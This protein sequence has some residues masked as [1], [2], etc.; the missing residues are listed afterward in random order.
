MKKF[1]L[2]LFIIYSSSVFSQNTGANLTQPWSNTQSLIRA[3]AVGAVRRT[4]TAFR[5]SDTSFIWIDKI[6]NNLHWRGLTNNDSTSG[7]GGGGGAYLLITDTTGKWIKNQYGTTLTGAANQ[8]LGADSIITNYITSSKDALINGLTFGKG[9]GNKLEN[10]AV[11]ITALSGITSGAYNVAIGYEALKATTSGIANV[12]IGYGALPVNLNGGYNTAIGMWSLNKNTSGNFNTALGM[13][14]LYKNTTGSNNIASGYSTLANNTSGI[15]NTGYGFYT[16]NQNIT[17]IENSGY[18]NNSLFNSLGSENSAFGT[19][20]IWNNT[21]GSYNTGFGSYSVWT[22]T[23]GT[24]NTAI[25]Y[26]ADVTSGALTN[27]TAIGSFAKVATSNTI[28]FGNISVTSVNTYGALTISNTTSSTSIGTGALIVNGG[29]GL[30]GNINLA[31]T[32]FGNSSANLLSA[33]NYNG[34]IYNVTDAGAGLSGG[35]VLTSNYGELDYITTVSRNIGISNLAGGMLGILK[36]KISGSSTLTIDQASGI[37]AISGLT[38]VFYNPVTAATTSTI[39][40]AAG[41]RTYLYS[42]N[43][44]NIYSIT[45]YYGLLVGASTEFMPTNITNRWGIYQ[46]GTTDKNWIAGPTY[47]PSGAATSRVGNS[48]LV[49]GTVTVSNTSVTA[50]SLIYLTKKTAGGTIGTSVDYS[51]SAG[52]SFTITSNNALDTSV[53]TWFIIN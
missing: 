13:S 26:Y 51:V 35:S 42:D 44:A 34:Y 49:A 53:Y 24:Y 20:S 27:A 5:A 32:L 16:L 1:I 41:L 50:S 46:E 39:T 14:A 43:T 10:T 15:A 30:S 48:T 7:G 3:N 52:T 28:Q 38:G 19:Y 17:G 37:R 23:T 6:T 22:N 9:T 36:P 29:F 33:G 25:G 47:M 40:H 8:K 2:L 4:I 45:N 18:G 11:G 31:G 21:T 12:G